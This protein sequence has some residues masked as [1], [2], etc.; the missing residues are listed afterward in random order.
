MSLHHSSPSQHYPLNLQ[1]H[2]KMAT[3]SDNTSHRVNAIL[4]KLEFEVWIQF[5]L[6]GKFASPHCIKSC[7]DGTLQKSQHSPNR[8]TVG[9][10]LMVLISIFRYHSEQGTVSIHFPACQYWLSDP[11]GLNLHIS[12]ATN[13]AV[14]NQFQ[15]DVIYDTLECF[16]HS[17]YC[18]HQ[19]CFKG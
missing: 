13:S 10:C 8:M 12:W 16:Y 14:W 6:L 17:R 3:S 19:V 5:L 4:A 18:D 9:H 11:H 1:A 2:Q 15:C 7:N